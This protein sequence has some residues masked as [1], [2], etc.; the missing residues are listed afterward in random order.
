MV[1]KGNEDGVVSPSVSVSVSVSSPRLINSEAGFAERL[2]TLTLAKS[3]GKC[4]DLLIEG[5]DGSETAR[6][7]ENIEGAEFEDF[8]DD[9][10]GLPLLSSIGELAVR[11]GV[12]RVGEDWV[13]G[14]GTFSSSLLLSSSSSLMWN[15][16]WVA[17]VRRGREP[18]GA[19]A[20]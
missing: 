20:P 2:K 17:G 18:S 12:G 8:R 11:A 7:W 19:K 15:F 5:V 10:N 4:T 3:W 1:G 14:K 6:R 13:T 16:A 9:F